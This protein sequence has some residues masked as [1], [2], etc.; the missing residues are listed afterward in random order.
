MNLN[1][2]IIKIYYIIILYELLFSLDSLARIHPRDSIE[3]IPLIR[4]HPV[5]AEDTSTGHVNVYLGVGVL[6]L[7]NWIPGISWPYSQC[8]YCVILI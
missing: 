2:A 1:I 5:A 6:L 8:H 7:R 4:C 3:P